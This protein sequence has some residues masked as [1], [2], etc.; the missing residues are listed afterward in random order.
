MIKQWLLCL[1][2]PVLACAVPLPANRSVTP[3]FICGDA[4]RLGC[5]FAYDE[6]TTSMDPTRVKAGDA[7][8]LKTDYMEAFFAKVHPRIQQPYVIVSHNS[9]D[10]APGACARFLDDPKLLAWFAQNYDGTPHPKMHPIPIGLA[11][12]CWGHGNVR[13][14]QR[15]RSMALPKKFLAYMNIAVQTFPSERRMV[16]E[17]FVKSPFCRYEDKIAHEPFLKTIASS[18]FVVSPRGNGLDTHRLW[19]ALYLGSIPIVKTSSID[20]LYEGLPVLVVEDWSQVNEEFLKRAEEEIR[21]KPQHMERL[22]ID[23]WM[24]QIRSYRSLF[25]SKERLQQ[26]N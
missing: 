9:D 12:A 7:I 24:Q 5:E 3:P 26:T 18:T 17:H 8:F 11:N 4:F 19:E 1:L 25:S 6:L 15:V 21:G 16:F 10:A 23:Y 2:I 20:G 13:T 14:L 22:S